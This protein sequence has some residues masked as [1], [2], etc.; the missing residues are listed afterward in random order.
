MEKLNDLLL[1][2]SVT[3]FVLVAF[4]ALVPSSIADEPLTFNPVIPAGYKLKFPKPK[5]EPLDLDKLAQAVAVAETSG[6]TDG[7]AVKRNNCF[8]IMRFWIDA[9]GKRQ[10]EPKYYKSHEESYADFKRIWSTYYKRFPDLALAKKWTGGDSPETWLCNV[11]T[12]Y[13]GNSNHAECKKS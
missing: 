2:A 12:K 9:N 10:R 11:K 5:E 4:Y 7:T 3:V 1:K 6:C 13:Y 8:G